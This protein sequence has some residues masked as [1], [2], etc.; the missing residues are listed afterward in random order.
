MKT[1]LILFYTSL[2]LLFCSCE[3][4]KEKVIIK[5]EVK[6]SVDSTIN[7][8]K[9]PVSQEYIYKLYG[10]L[11][12]DNLIP[13]GENRFILKYKSKYFSLI[14]KCENGEC[15]LEDKGYNKSRFFR[16]DFISP[17]VGPTFGGNFYK[18]EELRFSCFDLLYPSSVYNNEKAIIRY[19]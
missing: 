7:I 12:K 5:E 14:W 11:N 15:W 19:D 8:K 18:V 17:P 9:E 13:D 4:P 2:V 3:V 6:T 10:C 16:V 1:L